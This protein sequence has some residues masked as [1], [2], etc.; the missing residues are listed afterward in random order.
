ME[1]LKTRSTRFSKIYRFRELSLLIGLIT[2]GLLI[3]LATPYFFVPLNLFN[4]L[5]QVSV[6]AILAIGETLVLITGGID[7]SIGS[8]VSMSGVV[9]A[10]GLGLG[11]SP[12]IALPLGIAAG[13]LAG[14]V[15]G[16]VITRLKV[17]SFI[18]TLGMLGIAQGVA[19]LFSGGMPLSMRG[20]FQ[21]IGQG[22]LF[23]V[24]PVP[25]IIMFLVI[26]IAAILMKRSVL[27]RYIYAVGGSERA[28]LVSGV[29]INRIRT[30][31][32]M[33]SGGLA[34]LGGLIVS[35]NLAVADPTVATGLELDVITAA[36]IG[37]ASLSGGEGTAWGALLGAM[38]MGVLRNGF[39]MLHVSGY[40]QLVIMGL[41]VIVAVAIDNLSARR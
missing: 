17:N 36:V 26:L 34:G 35:S 3:S 7:L 14:L 24:V 27:A 10:Y 38:I 5:R 12:W 32:Y 4:V 22:K 19:L 16:V 15:N 6:V 28:A 11:L 33:I 9:A 29:R 21:F 18:A 23:G 25:A 20:G 39:V 2:L 40:W 41:F 1:N 31:V 13:I 37:G 8:I 30:I